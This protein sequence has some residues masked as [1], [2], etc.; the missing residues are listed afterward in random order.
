[1]DTEVIQTQWQYTW[2]WAHTNKTQM[3]WEFQ[4]SSDSLELLCSNLSCSNL[5]DLLYS[6]LAGSEVTTERLSIHLPG[7]TN[8]R[9][10]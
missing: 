7:K 9:L 1:M 10:G 2:I 4:R 8:S 5:T 6:N 3:L